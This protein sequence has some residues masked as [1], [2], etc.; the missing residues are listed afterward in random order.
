MQRAVARPV[1]DIFRRGQQKALVLQFTVQR[2]GGNLAVRP[3]GIRA[4]LDSGVHHAHSS[5]PFFHS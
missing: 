4:R 5:A 1:D 2:L 3:R